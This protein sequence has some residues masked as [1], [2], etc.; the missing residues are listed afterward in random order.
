MDCQPSRVFF[1]SFVFD[2]SSTPKVP[3]PPA[4]LCPSS[5]RFFFCGYSPRSPLSPH[6]ALLQ[7]DTGPPFLL[8]QPKLFS[9][10]GSPSPAPLAH[11][12]S[13]LP[14]GEHIP[15]GVA[16]PPADSLC[17]S[18]LSYPFPLL[19]PGLKSFLLVQA[20]F[21]LVAV[22]LKPVGHYVLLLWRRSGVSLFPGMFCFFFFLP[23]RLGS[24]F[25]FPVSGP[26]FW[27]T[28]PPPGH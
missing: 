14:G 2:F 19:D 20:L 7:P 12:Y 15:A 27:F 8:P 11:S 24:Y 22:F 21:F 23:R 9:R 26:L 3:R 4:S 5:N 25:F 6:P 1:F 17:L 18:S 13:K 28:T 10:L 16:A